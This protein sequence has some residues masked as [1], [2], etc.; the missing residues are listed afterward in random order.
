MVTGR[1]SFQPPATAFIK[2]A[3][4][5][6]VKLRF[7]NQILPKLKSSRS[8]TV[9]DWRVFFPFV[10][11]FRGRGEATRFFAAFP[12]ET[13]GASEKTAR[14]F[15]LSDF[16]SLLSRLPRAVCIPCEAARFGAGVSWLL[17]MALPLLVQIRL[18]LRRGVVLSVGTKQT[19]SCCFCV[20]RMRTKSIDV[21]L[22]RSEHDYPPLVAQWVK[23]S[24][25]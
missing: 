24:G 11:G 6:S 1:L 17:R 8:S 16:S 14:Y 12:P 18:A 21:Y 22:I 10:L 25:T 5:S 15:C 19:L 9:A 7:A 20:N 3:P 2:L 13:A 4:Y 23:H